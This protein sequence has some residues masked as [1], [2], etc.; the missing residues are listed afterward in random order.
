MRRRSTATSRSHL[1]KPTV[2][3]LVTSSSNFTEPK[4]QYLITNFT[5]A[6]SRHHPE[7]DEPNPHL[8]IPALSLSLITIL[9]STPGAHP[10]PTTIL[11][12]FL[13]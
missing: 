2:I 3:P 9:T 4:V 13:F 10:F 8:S 11:Y 6:I 12:A 7:P 1:Q 5:S